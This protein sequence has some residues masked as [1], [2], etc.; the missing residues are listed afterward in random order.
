MFCQGPWRRHHYFNEY[1]N[2]RRRLRQSL[3]PGQ[4]AVFYHGLGCQLVSGLTPCHFMYIGRRWLLELRLV[5][6][7]HQLP[8]SCVYFCNL[9][10]LPNFAVWTVHFWW[11]AKTLSSFTVVMHVI[12]HLL[13]SMQRNLTQ[14]QTN[15]F[16]SGLVFLL[17]LETQNWFAIWAPWSW[18]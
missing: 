11:H 14:K 15:L 12:S 13:W 18:T 9:Q 3:Q 10:S 8:S 17:F 7:D 1:S 16:T 4:S 6:S 5:I 2:A